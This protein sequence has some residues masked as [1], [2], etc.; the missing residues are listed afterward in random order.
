MLA[1]CDLGLPQL[2]AQGLGF[3]GTM[4]HLLHG[5][6]G[7]VG[8]MQS[9]EI[10]TSEPEVFVLYTT[11][12]AAPRIKRSAYLQLYAAQHGCQD[13]QAVTG[14]T[15]TVIFGLHGEH[16]PSVKFVRAACQR[17]HDQALDI[18][19]TRWQCPKAADWQVAGC[20]VLFRS[21]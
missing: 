6:D 9:G 21:C 14:I 19:Q 13:Q 2:S 10:D 16:G 18:G 4:M 12:A 3:K 8:L 1:M 17:V 7:S 5:T 20:F 11:S 15:I